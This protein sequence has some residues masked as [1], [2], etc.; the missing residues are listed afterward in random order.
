MIL[1]N[2]FRNKTGENI[3]EFIRANKRHWRDIKGS[4]SNGYILMLFKNSVTNYVLAPRTVKSIEEETGCLPLAILNSFSFL[5]DSKKKIYQSFNINN[6]I[7]YKNYFYNISDII[8]S[9]YLAIRFFWRRRSVDDLLKLEFKGIYI[10]DLVYDTILRNNAGLYTIDKIKWTYF[11]YF[12]IAYFQTIIYEK[13]F[14]RY[15][16]KYIFCGLLIFIKWGIPARVADKHGAVVLIAKKNLMKNYKGLDVSEGQYRPRE[17]DVN[18]LKKS[19]KVEADVDRY[20]S[21]RFSGSIAEVDAMRSFKGKAGYDKKK[22]CETLGI[23]KDKPIVFIMAH[24]FS[25]GPHHSPTENL[26]F[27]DYYIWLVETIKYASRI[28]TVNWVVKP[29]PMSFKYKEEG[30]VEK[31]VALYGNANIHLAPGDFST[32][33]IKDFAHAIVTVQGKAALEFGCFGIPSVVASLAPYSGY[34]LAVEPKIKE[35]YFGILKNIGSISK[36]SKEQI[37]TAKVLSA[38]MFI[39][40]RTDDALVHDL[41]T[42]RSEKEEEKWKHFYAVIKSYDR[43]RDGMYLR[44]KDLINLNF[45]KKYEYYEDK[46]NTGN[47]SGA[48]RL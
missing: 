25:D 9:F 27:R 5:F 33:N 17:S 36:L 38:I 15:D 11:K 16:I 24:A 34:G 30:A 47:Y 19:E 18:F 14:Q 28:K 20:M 4:S 1:K 45:Y 32:K 26:L 35:E 46:K 3:Q 31:L 40:S 42:F 44:I 10:G 8:K 21:E 43:S 48:R 7:Y 37:K 41:P 22:L 29:H 6:F 23:E 13:I 12:F 2:L 39:Y